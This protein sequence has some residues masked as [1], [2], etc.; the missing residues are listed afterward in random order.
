RDAWGLGLGLIATAAL[1]GAYAWIAVTAVRR[2]ITLGQMTMY[3][4]LFRQGQAAVSAMRSAVGGMYEDNL[5]LSTL[6]EYLETPVPE[7]AG[8]AKY[9]PHPEDGVRFEDVGFRYPDAEGAA[10]EHI[11]LHLR[12]GE[13]LALVGEN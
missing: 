2:L 9:G 5:Y 3:V 7:P 4:A 12:P 1:Y 10:L 8:N 11:N 6:Y 13:S